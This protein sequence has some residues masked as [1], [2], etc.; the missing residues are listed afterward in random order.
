M[1][2]NVVEAEVVDPAEAEGAREVELSQVVDE[3]FDDP[4]TEEILSDDDDTD[5]GEPDDYEGE[6]EE[7]IDEDDEEVE[8]EY[9]EETELAGDD[10][11]GKK[12]RKKSKRGSRPAAIRA[13]VSMN[14]LRQMPTDRQSAPPPSDYLPADPTDSPDEAEMEIDEDADGVSGVIILPG[15][16][17]EF[18]IAIGFSET[19][20]GVIN[21]L[22]NETWNQVGGF[23]SGFKSVFK[24]IGAGAGGIVSLA[25]KIA[26]S[27]VV[28]KLFNAA[29]SAAKNPMIAKM[30]GLSAMAFPAAGIAT[31]AAAAGVK[32]LNG[33][34]R[35]EPAAIKQLG[36]IVAKAQAGNA[37]ST[38]ALENLAKIASIKRQMDAVPGGYSAARRAGRGAR[39]YVEVPSYYHLGTGVVRRA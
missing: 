6:V 25:K 11:V 38:A 28:K 4:T 31:K 39:I 14:K 1:A 9:E 21:E 19:V 37:T 12:K 7:I 36:G 35:K 26:R 32:L 27:R 2:E 22:S 24:K 10:E 8:L 34:K 3:V 29:A 23:W 20:E 16:N 18:G 33:V 30:T 15:P 5:D 13:K 17:N